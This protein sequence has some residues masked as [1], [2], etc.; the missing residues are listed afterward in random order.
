VSY[1]Q[2]FG[3]TTLYP[4]DV[5]YLALSLTAD[6][7]LEW[8]LESS[9]LAPVAASIIDVTPTGAFAIT[10]PDAT[11]T[12]PG[13]TVLFNN[14]GPSVVTVLKSGG[15]VLCSLGA[16]EQW[17]VYLSSN[18]TAAGDWRVFRYGA[19]TASAQAASLAGYGLVAVGN[20]LAQ[21]QQV[22]L[23]NSSYS[24]GAADRSKALVWTGSSGTLNLPV[25]SAVGNDYFL[26]VRNSGTGALLVDGAGSDLVNGAASLSMQPGD[27]AVFITD[28]ANW[29]TVGLG[30]DPVFAFDYTSVSVSGSTYTLSGTELNRVAYRFVGTL[31]SD[32]VVRVPNTVQ[33]Y[34]VWNDTTG[35]SFTLSVATL[36]QSAPLVVPRGS[37]GIYYSDGSNMVK[38]DTASISL[39]INLSDG[40]TGASTAA[41]ARI[42]LGGSSV[43]IAVFTAATSQA[44]QAAIGIPVPPPFSLGTGVWNGVTPTQLD[45]TIPVGVAY[46][47]S[48]GQQ[49]IFKVPTSSP[50]GAITLKVGSNAAVSL[51]NVDGSAMNLQDLM[52]AASYL[53]IFDGTRFQLQ[54][55]TN[56]VLSGYAQAT[57]GAISGYIVSNDV[58]N[59]NTTLNISVGNCRD[60]TNSRNIPRTAGIIKNLF[61]VWAAGTNQGGRDVATAPAANETWHVHAILNGTSGVTDVLL[62]K[63]ATAPTLPSG[64]TH[65]RRVMSVVLDSSANIRGFVQ[66]GSYVQLKVRNAEFANTSNGVAAGTLRNM[67]VPLGLK[68]LLDVYY[69]STTSGGSTTDPVFSGCYDPDVGVP[70]GTLA[71]NNN[72]RWAQ[73]RIQ[74]GGSNLD[75]RYQTTMIQVYTNTNAQIFTASN[76]TGDT[77]AGGVVGWLDPRDNFF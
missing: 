69:Q 43:G 23:F 31:S 38:A 40:G 3:G 6:T 21:A 37:R 73:L 22:T 49:I 61:A 28:G 29:Y 50:S 62:S 75:L 20:T 77:I 52:P 12:A 74:W 65:F 71:T 25:A 14:L 56:S 8:P 63:S 15:G 13:Q 42:N 72:A 1:T 26:S 47:Q 41:G 24:P 30:Q 17:Q 70:N 59:P 57:N 5:S 9:T 51:V 10:M 33:Q 4:S 19:A 48:A 35:G 34:W 67:Q 68:L 54:T 53:A 44:A 60:S 32:I 16:G 58:T 45:L 46:S 2:V 76:D 11:L 66:S 7:T 36:T 55:P 64:Y 18:T 27:S 39:P